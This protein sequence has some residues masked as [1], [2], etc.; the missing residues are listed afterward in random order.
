MKSSLKKIGI[1]ILDNLPVGLCFLWGSL[2]VM[3]LWVGT[4]QSRLEAYY[5]MLLC[6]T[7][8]ILS[9]A[10]HDPKEQND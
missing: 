7:W 6:V 2:C 1:W 9:M 10:L 8:L 4:K 3:N 5:Q